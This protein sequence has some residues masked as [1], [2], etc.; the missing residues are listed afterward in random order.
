MNPDLRHRLWELFAA[1]AEGTL[2]AP[3]HAEL[4]EALRADP[5][6]RT[7]WFLHQ[8]LEIGLHSQLPAS[9]AANPP[10]PSAWRRRRPLAAAVAAGIAIGALSTSALF[11]TIGPLT[12][13]VT[14]LLRESFE[15]GPAP[16]RTGMPLRPGTW[17]GDH[18]EVSGPAEGI[19]PLRGKKMLRFLTAQYEGGAQKTGYNSD[20]HRVLDLQEHSKDLAGGNAWITAEACFHA[21]AC[22][23]PGRYLCGIELRALSD[24]PEQGGEN[25]M[26]SRIFVEQRASSNTSGVPQNVSRSEALLPAGA[27]NWT[28][29]RND[30]HIPPGTRYVLVT[31][32]A[33]DAQAAARKAPPEEVHF[34]GHFM[35]DI[36]ISLSVGRP[37]P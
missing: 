28:R 11:A 32:H 25:A 2:D 23:E 16:L 22:A 19:Q 37:M 29:L 30:L 27:P 36:H 17:G 3:Q 35:D 10:A 6:A 1:H 31:L 5:E 21:A 7:L 12:A 20:L 18:T 33:M 4:E 15:A 26:W 24:L 13:R 9:A 14:K 8:D 34:P